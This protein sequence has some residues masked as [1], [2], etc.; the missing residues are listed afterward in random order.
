[1]SPTPPYKNKTVFL[2]VTLLCF[3][4]YG[5]TLQNGYNLDDAWAFQERGN[6]DVLT[7][8]QESFTTSFVRIGELNYGYRP[9]SSFVF[10][11]EQGLFGQNPVVSHFLNV[12]IYALVCFLLFLWL[13][14]Q[15]KVGWWLAVSI[16]LTFLLLPVHSEVVNSVK[17]RDELLSAFFG[18]LFLIWSWKYYRKGGTF[19]FILALLFFILS[20][21]SKP[22]TI[23]LLV[24]VPLGLLITAELNKRR[25]LLA[26]LI[27]I[28]SLVILQTSIGKMVDFGGIKKVNEFVENPLYG[29]HTPMDRVV[30]A[31]NSFGF[32]MAA[33]IS[34]EH[35]SSYYGYDTIDFL[36][37][38]A[39]YL[40]AIVIFAMVGLFLLYMFFRRRKYKLSLFAMIFLLSCIGPFLNVLQRMPGVVGD[41]L[42]FFASLGFAILAGSLVYYALISLKKRKKELV[43]A[44]IGAVVIIAGFWS[45]KTVLRNTDWYD[46]ESLMAAD[47]KVYPRS[48]KMNMIMGSVQFNKGVVTK[49]DVR[50]IKD[51]EKVKEARGYFNK[52]LKVYDQ[53]SVAIYNI[54]WVDTYILDGDVDSTEQ[55]WWKLVEMKVLDSADVMPF[56]VTLMQRKGETKDALLQSLELCKGGNHQVGLNG[57][58]IALTEKKWKVLWEFSECLYADLGQRRQQLT[59][60]WKGLIPVEP[61][62]AEELINALIEMDA[63]PYYGKIKVKYLMETKD[64]A[65]AMLLLNVMDQTYKNDVEIKL[66]FGNLYTSF[67]QKENALRAF[68]EALALD[69]NNKGLKNYVNSLENNP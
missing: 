14:K 12:F 5:N 1:M 61:E 19:T 67:N 9:V 30:V 36:S 66:L 23:P 7:E 17:N 24:V 69:P 50:E 51:L 10:A 64:F 57:M 20:V 47:L 8:L 52:A 6:A 40:A 37:W 27:P 3:I 38:H 54:A 16:M 58:H 28:I 22:N 39:G 60:L 34:V 25:L 56:I 41:R 42:V 35:F 48:V 45:V 62:K 13:S 68:K 18:L 26:T 21:L 55:R 33:L 49:G 65:S 15:L 43:Y 46:L 32:Y 63:T 29:E 11:L 31:S 59:A 2:V 53:H 4:L 44:G